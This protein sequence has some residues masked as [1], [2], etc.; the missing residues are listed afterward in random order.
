MCMQTASPATKL[1]HTNEAIL[2]QSISTEI[3]EK[4]KQIGHYYK[5][6]RFRPIKVWKMHLN[7]YTLCAHILDICNYHS[8]N[9][10]FK[11]PIN[12]PYF[13]NSLCVGTRTVELQF[14]G[15][16]TTYRHAQSWRLRFTLKECVQSVHNF[17][18]LHC[19][20]KI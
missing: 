5:P 15:I 14:N 17:P 13:L 20:H 19:Q 18:Q 11:S 8:L 2:K 3:Y 6:G 16:T 1:I 12:E 7:V 10:E 4:F 9:Y